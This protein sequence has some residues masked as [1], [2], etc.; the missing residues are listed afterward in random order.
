MIEPL[1]GLIV[2][3]KRGKFKPNRV[4]TRRRSENEKA[5][6]RQNVEVY[7]QR[8][9]AGLEIFDGKERIDYAR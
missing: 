8:V 7:R 5:I 1:K 6:I 2:A 3:I 9:E 4:D